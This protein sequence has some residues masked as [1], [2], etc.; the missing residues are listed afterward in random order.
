MCVFSGRNIC[1]YVWMTRRLHTHMFLQV[2]SSYTRALAW[3][4]EVSASMWTCL[5]CVRIIC[6]TVIRRTA[7]SNMPVWALF[8]LFNQSASLQLRLPDKT[9]V[10][11][12]WAQSSTQSAWDANTERD[13]GRER[14]R[15]RETCGWEATRSVSVSGAMWWKRQAAN[16]TWRWAKQGI[17]CRSAQA[18][19]TQH[20]HTHTVWIPALFTKSKQVLHV[21]GN[22]IACNWLWSAGLNGDAGFA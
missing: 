18:R 10:S 17:T 20:T 2:D 19:N 15:D 9:E 16:Q 8:C 21:E 1:W 12:H 13:G 11:Q 4:E 22:W 14:L 6:E 3:S 7:A 5:A